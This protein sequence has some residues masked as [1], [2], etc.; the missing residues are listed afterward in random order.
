[1]STQTHSRSSL[2]RY[3]WLFI[4]LTILVILGG[5]TY[6]FYNNYLSG[7][8]WKPLLQQELKDLVLRSSDS[9]YHI[10]YS[11]FDLN[12]TSG[13]ATLSDF[14]LLPDTDIYKKLVA[15]KKA[16]DNLF[17]LSVK[18]LTIKN[19]GARK[20]YQEKILDIDNITIENPNLTIVNKRYDFNDT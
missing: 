13:N 1:M 9:L 7:N 4:T 3:K 18:K 16:P 5:T 14:R 19:V 17:T 20:A 8:K 6:Y 15:R 10:E 12:I 11:D 2:K